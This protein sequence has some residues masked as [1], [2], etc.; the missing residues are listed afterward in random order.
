[1]NKPNAIPSTRPVCPYF[2]VCGGCD[3]QDVAYADQLAAKEE[4]VRQ[5]FGDAI[6]QDA[7][8]P[9]VG[10]PGEYP[11]YYRGKIRFSFIERDGVVYPSRHQRGK[12]KPDIPVDRC[13]LLSPQADTLMNITA[14]FA[15]K[16]SWSLYNPQTRTGWLKHLL[17]REGKRTNEMLVALVTDEQEMP[18]IPEWAEAIRQTVPQLK[19]IYHSRSWGPANLRFEDTLQWGDSG[20]TEKVGR[21]RFWISPHAFFQTNDTNVER[22]Y[23]CVRDHANLTGKEAVWDLYAGSA[24]IGTFLSDHAQKVLCVEANP[25][26]CQDAAWAL[27]HNNV[28]NVRIL[29]GEVEQVVTNRFHQDE[30]MPDV[31]VVDPPRAGL[32]E[33]FR[34]L[35]P[36]L[37]AKR[38]V[39]VSCNPTTCYRDVRSLERTHRVISATPIDMFPHIWQCELVLTLVPR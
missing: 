11:I 29:Q 23:E 9:I 8:Q 21:F 16:H 32:N 7:W 18:G 35:L 1:V 4:W 25:A 28:S 33:Q 36:H 10:T 37:G 27:A 31:I 22:L 30:G 6:P 34:T 13:F 38:I 12:D 39:Y 26:N 15:T 19:S 17:I 2:G 20:I 24:T 5:L 14:Q 3:C